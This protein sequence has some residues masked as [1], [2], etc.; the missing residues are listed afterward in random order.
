M[1]WCNGEY[2]EDL[3][4]QGL[5]SINLP[6]IWLHMLMVAQINEQYILSNVGWYA[7][8]LESLETSLSKKGRIG[9]R[10]FAKILHQGFTIN[11]FLGLFQ[12]LSRE[13]LAYGFV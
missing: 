2:K 9:G 13:I 10:E 3:D 1:G 5:V 11:I 8:E 12:W 6:M 7:L 4:I